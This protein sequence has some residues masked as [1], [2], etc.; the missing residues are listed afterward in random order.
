[1]VLY[2]LRHELRNPHNTHFQ[3]NLTSIG[4]Y[5][6]NTKLYNKLLNINIDEI[7]SSPYKRALETVKIY[8]L[9]QNVPIKIDWALSEYLD[10]NARQKNKDISFPNKKE[11]N[12]IH[13][14]YNIDN[15]YLPTT[16]QDYID[17]YF[18]SRESFEK[19][20]D[21]FILFL[22]TKLYQNILVVTHSAIC[23][24]ITEKLMGNT[25]KLEMGQC[26]KLDFYPI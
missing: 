18:E 10:D 19:R 3:T 20:V 22:Y 2:L 14:N 16:E 17:T 12:I 26:F 15:E 21:N 13:K 24:R 25:K 5:N 23:D 9:S 6:S 1:M 4:K 11:Q 8:S 7:Y